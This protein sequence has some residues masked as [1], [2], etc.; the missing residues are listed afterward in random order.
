[1][2]APA[3]ARASRRRRWAGNRGCVTSILAVIWLAAAASPGH[4]R[5]GA[6]VSIYSDERFRGYSLS[7]GRPVGILDLSYDDPHGLYGALSGSLVASRE[8]PRP[9]SATIN[10]GYARRLGSR[11]TGDVGVIHSRYSHY[12]GLASGRSYTEVYAGLSGKQVGARL[13][14]SPNYVGTA[15]WTMHGEING[16]FDLTP[17][18]RADGALGALLPVGGGAYRGSSRLQWDARVG[19]SQRIGPISL[20]AALTTRGKGP[21]IYADGRHRRAALVI[22]IST[23]L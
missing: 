14:V 23:A 6:V 11:L 15:G 7:D 22:G 8:G 17:T 16:H 19:L 3:G 4:A 21:S 13:S 20:H 18:L 12:S 10:A 9:L 1:V 2:T 5:A